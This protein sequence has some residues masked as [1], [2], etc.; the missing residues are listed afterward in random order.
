[1]RRRLVAGLLMVLATRLLMGCGGSGPFITPPTVPPFD[2]SWTRSG[3]NPILSASVA[4]EETGNGEP[5]ARW[6]GGT[7]W[8]LWYNGGWAHPGIGYATSTDGIAWTKYA[9][10]PVYGQG[11]SGMAGNDGG[12]SFVTKTGSTYYLF[13]TNNDIPRVNVAT[14]TD[15]IAWTTQVSSITLPAG[16]TLWGNRAVWIEGETWK[17]LQEAGTSWAI[18]LYTSADGLT[19]SIGNGGA[20]L[21]TLQVAGGDNYGGPTIALV[22]GVHQPT[23]ASTYRIWYHDGAGAST[24]IYTATS[25]DL[26]TWTIGNGGSPV[27]THTGAGFEIDQVADPSVVV[28][29]GTAYLYYTG[30][31]N[32]GTTSKIGVATA[33]ATY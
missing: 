17:M 30:V 23:F 16:K 32:T 15:G 13:T 7:A 22:N 10:N 6:E 25:S 11:G 2:A 27:L 26:I 29:N 21:S 4:W 8:K 20:A 28:V 18:Y 1:M 12:Q 24:N 3:S 9:S 19:W 31:D 33:P 14:S 5:R